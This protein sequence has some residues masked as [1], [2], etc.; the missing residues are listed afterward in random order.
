MLS[1]PTS[2]A[3]HGGIA[4][5]HHGDLREK[6]LRVC[7]NQLRTGGLDAISLRKAA[8]EIGVCHAAPEQGIA[9]VT[10]DGAYGSRKRRDAIAAQGAGAIISPCKNAKPQKPDTAGVVAG[11]DIL[12]TSKS[13]G[14]TTRRRCHGHHRRGRPKTGMPM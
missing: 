5:H 11:S 6:L 2:Q 9:S 10:A 8:Q 12:R 14:R 7:R 3:G 13:V 4:P 1:I